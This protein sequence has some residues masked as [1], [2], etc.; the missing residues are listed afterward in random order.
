MRILHTSDWHLGRTLHGENLHAHQAEFHDWLLDLVVARQVDV[1]VIAGDVYDRAVPP[2]ESVR[3]LGS[4]LA[5]LAEVTTVVL[6]PGNH[7]SADRLGFGSALM[8]AGV[9]ILADVPGLDHPVQVP[10]EHGEVL[11]FGLPYLEPDMARTALAGE[12]QQPLA[13]SHEAVTRAAMDRVRA[14]ITTHTEAGE[15]GAN[16]PRSVVLAHTFVTGGQ[17]SGSERDLTVGGVDSVPAGVL[18]G[19][20]YVALGHLHG[21]QDL[22]ATVGT[23][24]W[25]SGSPLAFSFSEKNHRK[26]V[27]LVELGEPGQVSVERIPTPVPRRLTELRGT[28]EEILAQADQHG[29]DWLKAIITD[30]ARPPHLLERLRARY[31]HLLHT[32]HQPAGRTSTAITPTVRRDADPVEVMDE[33]LAFVTGGEPTEAEHQVLEDAYRTVRTR[34]QEAS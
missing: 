3:L 32:E 22:S 4:T 9:H 26:S 24:A 11:F 16:R 30:P 15:P 2:V 18:D 13:R 5:R 14:R 8:R 7:D 21:C 25:Y 33:F 1:V 6:T 31:P 20:D 12:G 10:D 27:L 34:G 28:L 19:V 29:E 17:S 23:T